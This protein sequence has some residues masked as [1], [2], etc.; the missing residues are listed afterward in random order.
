MLSIYDELIQS[1]KIQGMNW[2]YQAGVWG[3]AIVGFA[4]SVQYSRSKE[5]KKIKI[6][7]EES[8]PKQ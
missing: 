8:K 2:K 3:V 6:D 1:K 7:L 4:L 5:V